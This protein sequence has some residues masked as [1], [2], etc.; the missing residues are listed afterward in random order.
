MS[1]TNCW[2][3]PRSSAR[4]ASLDGFLQRFALRAAD[5]L[6]F[7]RGFIGLLENGAFHVRWAAENSRSQ[8]WISCYPDGPVSRALLTKEVFWSDDPSQV[9]GINLEILTKFEVRQLLTVP[10]LDTSGEVL[11]MFGVLDRQ[12]SARHLAGGHSSRA[13][14]GGASCGRAGS[15]PQSSPIRAA[16]Q[17]G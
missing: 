7:G 12:D 2:I 17:A 14:F 1:F 6:G 10:L 8:R 9:P 15:N 11:G 13:G 3:S 4:S 16:P 5:F